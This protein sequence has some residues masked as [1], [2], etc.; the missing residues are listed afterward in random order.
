MFTIADLCDL[1]FMDTVEAEVDADHSEPAETLLSAQTEQAGNEVENV[2]SKDILLPAL[3]FGWP[4]PL[5][6][7]SSEDLLVPPRS[8]APV[9]DPW[10]TGPA[11]PE[12]AFVPQV[13]ETLIPPPLPLSPPPLVYAIILPQEE[14]N[15]ENIPLE[16]EAV[17]KLAVVEFVLNMKKPSLSPS[18]SPSPSSSLSRENEGSEDAEEK[19]GGKKE[20]PSVRTLRSRFES[21]ALLDDREDASVSE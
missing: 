5:H 17:K 1:L 19:D 10:E 15:K 11:I 8:I 9:P 21:G 14:S 6:S 20:K 2:K 16:E 18:P 13:E 4:N 3:A 7:S 12:R